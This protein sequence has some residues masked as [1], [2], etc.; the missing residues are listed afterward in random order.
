MGFK[1]KPTQEAH[2][3]EFNEQGWDL[4]VGDVDRLYHY[5]SGDERYP[6]LMED[7]T[8]T[9]DWTFEGAVSITGDSTI[10]GDVEITGDTTL[11]GSLT[12]SGAASF[13]GTVAV[14]G[15]MTISAA[16]TM[17]TTT[18]LQFRDTALHIASLDDGH[19]DL[20]ADTAVDLN[21]TTVFV[22]GVLG[23]GTATVPLGGYGR[24]RIGVHGSNIGNTVPS[25]QFTT[26]ASSYPIMQLMSMGANQGY[27]AF[28]AFYVADTAAWWSSSA[29]LNFVLA[30]TSDGIYFYA[31]SGMAVGGAVT[32]TPVLKIEPDAELL[33]SPVAARKMYWRDSGLHIASLDDG[34][35]DITADTSIDLNGAVVASSSITATSFVIGANTLTTTEWAFLDGQDQAVKTTDSVAFAS[36]S[37]ATTGKTQY[38]DAAVYIQ[39]A[40]DGH[41]DLTADVAIDLNGAVNVIGTLT[42]DSANEL[43]L[44]DADIHICSADDG[45]LDLTADVSIDLNGHTFLADGAGLNTIVGELAAL[46]TDATDGFLY[47]PMCNGAPTGLPTGYAWKVAI[48]FDY[49]NDALYVYDG[50]WLH[51][52]VA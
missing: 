1:P 37:L 38:R 41:L 31:A 17:S 11:S 8:V 33:F 24:A 15:A 13:S 48:V 39:S 34:H 3:P 44:R 28:D 2:R 27:L 26:T 23:V 22:N 7:E 10:D 45:H 36:V 51:V 12:V 47:I 9:G 21:A 29:S 6:A 50:G 20:T 32:W 42:I 4:L 35:L 25:M 16:A 52:H 49:A 30:K 14:S 43:Y 46:A 40:D 19:L 18:R 5:A